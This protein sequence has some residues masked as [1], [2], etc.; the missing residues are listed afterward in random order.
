[1]NHCIFNGDTVVLNIDVGCG[2][3]LPPNQQPD[4]YGIN[5]VARAGTE[6][7]FVRHDGEHF[8]FNWS[9]AHEYH[10]FDVAVFALASEFDH[11]H[12]ICEDVYEEH[13]PDPYE[14]EN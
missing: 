10:M 12:E 3:Y 14:W 8:V 5:V 4:G 13:R 9:D 6:I 7:D 11:D 2:E 1:M